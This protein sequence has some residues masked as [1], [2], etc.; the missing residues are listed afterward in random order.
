MPTRLGDVVVHVAV[1]EV[2][3]AARGRAPGQTRSTAALARAMNSG[4]LATGTETS[5]LMLPPSGFCASE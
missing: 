2:R 3:R 4:I 1:A 5:F